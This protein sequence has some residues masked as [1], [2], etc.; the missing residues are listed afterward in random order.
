MSGRKLESLTLRYGD[1]LVFADSQLTL[2]I[3]AI[4]V[5]F[6][7][8]TTFWFFLVATDLFQDVLTQIFTKHT[9]TDVPEDPYFLPLASYTLDGRR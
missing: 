1:L 7:A 9:H 2:R 8:S 6:P 4:S 5:A 3:T